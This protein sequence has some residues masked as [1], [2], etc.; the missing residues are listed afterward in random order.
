MP[1]PLRVKSR[2][3]LKDFD[4]GFDDGMQKEET[5]GR[6]TKLCLKIGELQELL[7]ANAERALL[8]VFQGMDG[9]GKDGSVRSVLEFVNPAGVETANFKE[10]SVEEKAHDYLWRIHKAIP[11]RGNIGVFNRSHYEEVLVVRVMELAAKKVWK[12][13]YDQINAFE[14]MLA[15]NG[16]LLLKFFLHLS[17]DEQASRFRDR[18]ARPDKQWKFATGDLKTRERWDDFQ[19]A[20]EDV[21]NKCSTPHAPWHIVPADHKWY[22]N[23]AIAQTVVKAMDELKMKWPAPREDLS[24]VTIV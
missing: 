8:L 2:V 24:K 11:R 6:T 10:P 20:Y 23:F 3:R 21:L 1:Q 12:A 18:L 9:S 14:E 13:R 22:R 16:V 19:E 5:R 4:P 17:K 15:A 7:Y